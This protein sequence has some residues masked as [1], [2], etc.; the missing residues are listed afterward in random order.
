MDD[1]PAGADAASEAADD[2][3]ETEELGGGPLTL[4]IDV[5]EETPP[6]EGAARVRHT[7]HSAS[8][9]IGKKNEIR[10]ASGAALPITEYSTDI[11]AAVIHAGA[12]KAIAA[13][14]TSKVPSA[15]FCSVV[16]TS[17]TS[18]CRS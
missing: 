18:P 7:R 17:R 12:L 5:D 10:I 6:A 13:R 8:T 16:A 11:E 4:A 3:E 15:F 9:S 1:E 2:A 14:L